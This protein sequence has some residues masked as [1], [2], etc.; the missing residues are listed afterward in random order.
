MKITKYV[1]LFLIMMSSCSLNFLDT[2]DDTEEKENYTVYDKQTDTK[3][4]Y[5]S[6]DNLLWSEVYDF[7][8]SGQCIFVR[9]LLPSG[10]VLWSKIYSWDGDNVEIEAYYDSNDQLTWYNQFIYNSNNKLIQQVNYE[11]ASDLQWFN[12]FSYTGTG[13]E[14]QTIRFNN[15]SSLEWAYQYT[16]DGS[17]RLLESSAYNTTTNRTAY[18]KHEWNSSDQPLKKTGYGTTQS[19][20]TFKTT[21]KD[22]SFPDYGGVNTSNRNIPVLTIPAV[23]TTPAVPAVT[24]TDIELPSEWMSLWQY[25]SFGYSKVTLN[26]DNLPV[27]IKRD[28]PDYL[29]DLPIEVELSYSENKVASKTT[30]YNNQKVLKLEFLYDPDGY[31]I[32]IETT[33]TSLLIPLRYNLSYDTNHFPESISIFNESAM[34]QKFVY[35]YSVDTGTIADLQDFAKLGE[36]TINHYD[37]DNTLIES[38]VFDY[39]DVDT[40]TVT[41]NNALG[42][43]NGS[44]Q[45][46]YDEND[47]VTSLSSYNS[48]KN[49][50]WKYNYSYDDLNNRIAEMRLDENDIP[51]VAFSFDIETIFED[52]KRFLP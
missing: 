22:F 7:N 29:N 42:D 16:Y 14:L 36:P 1:L 5:N 52:L 35:V 18:I 24:L 39:N 43:P 46:T 27:Y 21:C 15:S 4:S 47:N 30:T 50:L 45:L 12:S 13:K 33:G 11:G 10:L 38:F 17:D 32:S 3:F 20:D 37:G 28:A 40:I 49:Q 2:D 34:L 51:E 26:S 44:Y 6:K 48:D 8:A 19:A 41:V 23:P 25:D 9:H 31:P